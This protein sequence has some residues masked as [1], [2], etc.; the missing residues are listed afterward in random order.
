MPRL[1]KAPPN[2]RALRPTG[3]KFVMDRKSIIILVLCA[4]LFVLW[5]KIVNKMYPPIP[6]TISTNQVITATNTLAPGSNSVAQPGSVSPSATVPAFLVQTNIPEQ[7]LVVSNENAR[8]VFTSRGGGLKEIQLLNYPEV[9]RSRL[10]KGLGGNQV[11]TLN[12]PSGPPVLAILGDTSLQGD[13]VFQ[14]S[15]MT[16]GGVRAEKTVSNNLVIIKE[17][18]PEKEYLLHAS[19]RIENRSKDQVTLPAQEWSVGTAMPMGPQDNALEEKVLWYD[20]ARGNSV[21]VP[22]F[23]TNTSVLGIFSRTPKTIYVA[24]SNDVVWASA[25]NQFFALVTMMGTSNAAERV[26]VHS[27]DL[28][29]PG[30]EVLEN[31]PNVQRTPKGLEASVAFPGRTLAPGASMD[32][33]FNIFA[34][35]KKYE[36]LAD[37]GARFH[38]NLDQVMSFS[39]FS[40]ISKMLL[41]TMNWLHDV[42]KLNYG[43]IIVLTTV[44]IKL[45][46]WPLTRASTRSMKRMQELQPQLAALKEKY[47]DEPQKFSQKQWEFYKKNKVNPLGSCL[48]MLLQIPVF[49]G[50]LGMLRN[51]IELRGAGFLWITDLSQ[52]DRL[53]VIPGINFPVNLMPLIMG[54]S[55]FWLA[56]LTPPSPT[57]DP[58]Q[59]KIMRYLPLMMIVFLYNYSSGLALYWAVSNLMSVWQT[60]L[61]KTRPAAAAAPAPVPVAPQKKKK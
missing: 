29:E 40:S 32:M 23:S 52:P 38:N 46:F 18:T 7:L 54:A 12:N 36:M 2:A 17:F 20:G 15:P 5:L 49:F 30:R 53:F 44:I 34:G 4:G 9:V 41:I 59:Q 21:T 48:P 27:V 60:K 56:S 50:F 35:P 3:L 45:V 31:L 1:R 11:A 61:T 24:G 19:V 42:L 37:L 33:Q 13:G 14:L 57:M 26:T 55:Q 22:Y 51:A 10:S 8:Y 58:V 16:N 39:L 28:P 47:K 25:Q 6:V 43:F